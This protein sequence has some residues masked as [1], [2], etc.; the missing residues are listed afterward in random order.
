MGK[1]FSILLVLFFLAWVI[2]C[3]SG[4]DSVGDSTG[5]DDSQDDTDDDNEPELNHVPLLDTFGREIIL[6][7]VN[8]MGVQNGGTPE[9]YQKMAQKWGFNAVRILITWADLEPQQGVYDEGYLQTV[10]EKQVENAYQAG[11]NVII[12]M[13]QYHWSKCCGGMGMPEWICDDLPPWSIEWILQSGVFWS[14]PEYV[15]GFIAAWEKVAEYFAGDERVFAYDLFNEPMAGL[16]SLPWTFENQLLRPLYIRLIDEVRKRDPKPYIIIEPTIV[17]LGGFP[18]VMDPINAERLIYG[19][20]LYPGTTSEGGGYTFSKDVVIR[21]LEKRKYEADRFGAPLL[22]GEAGLSSSADG[23]EAYSRDVTELMD[24]ATASWTWWVYVCEN[25]G[26]G[27]CDASGEPKPEFYPYLTRP[28]PK[29]TTGWI[30][31]YRFDINSRMFTFTFF[32]RDGMEPETEIYVNDALHY[33]DGFIVESTDPPGMWDYTFDP[34]AKL[35]T[36]NC[37]PNQ[38]EHT[39]TIVPGKN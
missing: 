34:D 10:V 29:A 13:H 19:P 28:Y 3:N 9:D 6:H 20:H 35:L 8:F 4:G 12:N 24:E 17:T 33:P 1:K 16:L 31:S 38:A 22:I 37:D 30:K 25:F 39:I 36:V 21:H 11:L 32:T 7:G 26:M 23:A 27:L 5:D 15:D 14:H 18:C 2:S